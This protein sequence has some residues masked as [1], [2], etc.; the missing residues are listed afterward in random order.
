MCIQSESATKRQE[1]INPQ[2]MLKR[3]SVSSS[4]S[5]SFLS[6]S[7][8]LYPFILKKERPRMQPNARLHRS[9]FHSL[10]LCLSLSHSK[11]RNPQTNPGAIAVCYCCSFLVYSTKNIIWPLSLIQSKRNLFSSCFFPLGNSRKCCQ[12]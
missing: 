12:G 7:Y 2:K 6:L 5:L 9:P 1:G 4:L 11:L 3:T 10:S 8:F